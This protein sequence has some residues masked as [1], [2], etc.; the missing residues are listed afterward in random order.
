MLDVGD[1]IPDPGINTGGKKLILYF[2]PKDD[3]PGCTAE[4]CG[5]RDSKHGDTLIIGVSKDSTESHEKFKAKY[6]LNFD[7]ISDPDSKLYGAFGVNGRTT[8][9]I[10]ASGVIR[11]VWRGVKVPGHVEETLKEAENL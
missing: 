2:Y 7:L 10:D 11:K 1:K 5:F 8:F 9:L 6:G 4:A 3:T